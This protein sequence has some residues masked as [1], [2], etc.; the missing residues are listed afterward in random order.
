M[1]ER[2]PFEER[3]ARDLITIA[4][5]YNAPV[6]PSA[7]VDAAIATYRS[8]RRRWGGLLAAGVVVIGA[9][10]I[11]LSAG[12]FMQSHP[13]ASASPSTGAAGAWGVVR[14]ERAPHDP[15]VGHDKELNQ[16]IGGVISGG[17]G[18]VAWGLDEHR[19]PEGVGSAMAIWISADARTW[20]EVTFERESLTY[21]AMVNDIAAGPQGL[22]AVGGVCCTEFTSN[23]GG[24]ETP[25]RWFSADGEHWTRE[26]IVGLRP[27]PEM[28]TPIVAGPGGFVQAGAAK[29]QPAVW[30]SSDGRNWTAFSLVVRGFDSGIVNDI[31]VDPHGYLAVGYVGSGGQPMAAAWRSSNGADWKRVATDDSVLASGQ[32][33]MLE[34]VVA[35]SGG[36]FAVGQRAL[37]A[38]QQTCFPDRMGPSPVQS[39]SPS[40]AGEPPLAALAPCVTSERVRLS[41][42]DGEHWTEL[43]QVAFGHLK[44]GDLNDFHDT[45]AG[46]PGLIA[47]G[48]SY[49]PDNARP[50]FSLWTSADGARWTRAIDD[51]HFAWPAYVNAF[52]VHGDR[53]IAV[54][55]IDTG[56]AVWIG[57]RA[58]P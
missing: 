54:G 28:P 37:P 34:S 51:P 5:R 57:N 46:G 38:A 14:W 47:I 39:Q 42:Q 53:I 56:A 7:T 35:Y 33:L 48:Q 20:R 15:G 25:A 10:G 3:L 12:Q 8:R 41:S 30:F 49:E 9:V 6:D 16:W 27:N 44:P 43:P 11:G 4:D 24:I 45:R 13:P 31:T 18:Y 52:V 19:L 55:Q 22:V 26:P 40:A 23:G 50:E 29:D 58:R 17:P 1:P 21:R 2:D 32:I 36:L